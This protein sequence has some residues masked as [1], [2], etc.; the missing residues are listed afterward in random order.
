M[1]QIASQY[2][3]SLLEYQYSSAP[4]LHDP[5]S[6][7]F[8]F[9]NTVALINWLTSNL[10]VAGRVAKHPNFIHD[11]IEKLLRL[12]IEEMKACSRVGGVTFEA[13]LGSILQFL[14]T[15]LLRSDQLPVTPLIPVCRSWFHYCKTGN[16]S[17]KDNSSRGCRIVYRIRLRNRQRWIR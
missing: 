6:S 8:Y 2:L 14:S 13:A 3:E 7:Q 11:V 17:T 9:F 12:D 1:A 5:T 15:I 16:T 4:S 10:D